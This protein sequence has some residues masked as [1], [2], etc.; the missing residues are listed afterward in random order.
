MIEK[1]KKV[2]LTWDQLFV[3]TL[4]SKLIINSYFL[5]NAI[6]RL[7]THKYMLRGPFFRQKIAYFFLVENVFFSIKKI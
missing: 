3:M 5:I 6:L 2:V 4:I 7:C 1:D